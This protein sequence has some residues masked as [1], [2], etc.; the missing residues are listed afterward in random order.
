MRYIKGILKNNYL[1]GRKAI[2]LRKVK[3]LMENKLDNK[4]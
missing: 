2:R 3:W 4:H 1:I